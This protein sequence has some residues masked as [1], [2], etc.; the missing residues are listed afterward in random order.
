MD[1]TNKEQ[2]ESLDDL[3][4]AVVR[5]I[6]RRGV[7]LSEPSVWSYPEPTDIPHLNEIALQLQELLATENRTRVPVGGECGMHAKHAEVALDALLPSLAPVLE[8]A[9]RCVMARPRPGSPV[10]PRALR[11]IQE[12]A[13]RIHLLAER[14]AEMRLLLIELREMLGLFVPSDAKLA[15]AD[16][17]WKTLYAYRLDRAGVPREVIADAIGDFDEISPRAPDSERQDERDKKVD[18]LRKRLE[19]FNEKIQGE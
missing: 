5:F 1:G 7:S 9:D 8:F 13:P 4:A 12:S 3:L 16:R 2:P 14:A 15:L 10:G 19:R 17:S 18:N 6:K 11:R